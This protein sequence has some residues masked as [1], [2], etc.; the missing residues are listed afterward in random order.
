MPAD[1][2]KT[3]KRSW[4]G[5][6][7][8][9]SRSG[10]AN[11]AWRQG[12]KAEVEPKLQTSQSTRVIIAAASCAVAV[13]LIVWLVLLLRPVRPACLLLVRADYATNLAV[14]HNV[15]GAEGVRGLEELAPPPKG[16]GLFGA[17][18]LRPIDN[19]TRELNKSEEWDLIVQDLRT[20][21][22]F[23]EKTII[24]VMALHGASDASGQPY[25][26]PNN[27]RGP[28]DRLPIKAVLQGLA[29]LPKEKNKVLILE[30]AQIQA[31]WRLGMPHNDF[32]RQLKDLEPEIKGVENLWVL[33]A[34]GPDER[35]WASEGL[36]RTVFSQ[37]LIEGLAGRAAGTD[38]RVDL[39]ELYS[40]VRKNV[41]N[42]SWNA[43]AAIQEPVLLPSGEASLAKAQQVV[44]AST[45]DP[46]RFKAPKEADTSGLERAWRTYEALTKLSPPPWAHA[47]RQW[48]AY[49]AMLV[50]YDELTRAGAIDPAKA[51]ADKMVVLAKN[52][53]EDRF[54][55]L[56][57]ASGNSLVFNAVK[58][59]PVEDPTL[60]ATDLLAYWNAPDSDVNK[61]RQ[62]L[63]A[64]D[65]PAD[66]G[67]RPPVRSLI[68]DF[69]IQRAQADAARNLAR[70][71]ARIAQAKGS[72][73]PQPAEAHFTRMLQ[74]RLPPLEA[75]PELG[76][77][78]QKALS[79]RRLAERAAL[80][81]GEKPD[82]FSYSDQVVPWVRPLIEQADTTRRQA[83]DL[84]F[85]TEPNSWNEADDALSESETIYRKANER[86][87]KVRDA[88]LLRDMVLANL[89][90]YA[91]WTAHRLPAEVSQENLCEPLETLWDGTHR[92]TAMLEAAIGPPNASAS[93][94][95]TENLEALTALARA[96]R[97]GYN[98]V[99]A[100]FAAQKFDSDRD[101]PT[102][103]KQP[104]DWELVNAAAGV[105][106]PFSDFL[107]QRKAIWTR[108]ANI[109]RRDLKDANL[110]L[111]RDSK[112]AKA[113]QANPTNRERE[114]ALNL[115]KDRARIEGRMAL[116]TLGE[117]WFNDP[118][119]KGS[120]NYKGISDRLAALGKSEEWRTS[121]ELDGENQGKRWLRLVPE[122]RENAF[123]EGSQGDPV[124]VRAR[125][126]KADRL[127][128]QLDGAGAAAEADNEAAKKYRERLVHD[129]LLW[130]AE[131][132]WSDH[133]YDEDRKNTPY[134][135]VAGDKYL[136]EAGRLVPTSSEVKDAQRRLKERSRLA[137]E[138]T[139]SIVLTSEASKPASY[140]VVDEGKVP[141][142]SPV[143]SAKAGQ[144]LK[145]DQADSW[146]A[147]KR[148]GEGKPTQPL[149]FAVNCP[150]LE[151]LAVNPKLTRPKADLT[152]FDVQGFF[153]GQVFEARTPVEIHPLP[154]ISVLGPGRPKSADALASLSV[155]ASREIVDQYGEGNGAIAIVLDCSGSMTGT[156]FEKAKSALI[157]VL[158]GV[159]P[160]TRVS[161][162]IYG[163]KRGQPS[164]EDSDEPGRTIAHLH[165]P[166]PWDLNAHLPAIQGKLAGLVPFY[167][168]PLI[169]AMVRAKADL[170]VE[171]VRGFRTLVALTDGGDSVYLPAPVDGGGRSIKNP[172]LAATELKKFADTGILVNVVLFE[173]SKAE[174]AVAERQFKEPLKALD[175]PGQLTDANIQAL[176]EI[177]R[178][179]LLQKL[180]CKIMNNNDGRQVGEVEVTAEGDLSD[181]WLAPG[182]GVG[183]YELQV[184]TDRIFRKKI[185]VKKGDRLI[186]KLVP[187]ADQRLAFERGLYSDDFPM[188]DYP[189]K[190][191]FKGID[192]GNWRLAVVENQGQSSPRSLQLFAILEQNTSGRE[193]LH[194]VRPNL[195]WFELTSDFGKPGDYAVRWRERALYPAPVWQFDVPDWPLDP[196]GAPAAPVL[197][198]W[199]NPDQETPASA[200]L[201]RP[202]DFNAPL[203]DLIER[204]VPVEDRQ[205]IVIESVRAEYHTVEPSPGASPEST[206]CLVVRL[207]YPDAKNPYW[208][209]PE[210]LRGTPPNNFEHRF[211]TGAK[212]YTGL[213]W[214]VSREEITEKLDVLSLISL[215]KFKERT[216][217]R[218]YQLEV[219][220]QKPEIREKPPR[221]PPPPAIPVLQ[222]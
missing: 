125:L 182:L 87:A 115:I 113:P 222:R 118:A 203:R 141:P 12:A 43:R 84:L 103:E 209:D 139:E 188:G 79:V 164:Q 168:T 149:A 106:A 147:V 137:F 126:Q 82:L 42:W 208:I 171:Q 109:G 194:V 130:L 78:A 26:I 129:L 108:L 155:R 47:P 39:Y 22:K 70:A 25:L 80:A 162:L 6:G 45:G 51:L 207:R 205:S 154:E 185:E 88:L 127:S 4:K 10:G 201:S 210:S 48:R 20:K 2:S 41:R 192:A 153:R 196:G 179:A 100:Q 187:G 96:V 158:R 195:T 132:T 54:L 189:R 215:K 57:V 165:P 77:V 169:D 211:Y 61:A 107:E 119:F 89:P 3:P 33:S 53:E 135:Q 160:K 151:D 148:P 173:L 34:A 152:T 60:P 150:K 14:P 204:T 8:S 93:A 99:E 133:W 216:K 221:P 104:G 98:A 13:G 37:Y 101:N 219:K 71:A 95:G 177:L 29:K 36:R 85:A 24:I 74:L 46:P 180:A 199:W 66:E 52:M 163:Q 197:R 121:L 76:K 15:F 136:A 178:K 143:L 30:A 112:A 92:L 50:R 102:G 181:A 213:F 212:R 73:Y 21:N 186:V 220:L 63:E 176:S 166:Q 140:R 17:Q 142:G 55:K 206:P 83:E 146:V 62:K 138:K 191:P 183:T 157:D 58:G 128:R 193:F 145:L 202:A 184:Q 94:E 28:D 59:G 124:T 123:V 175:P 72:D 75:R 7:G 67:R 159:P 31:D 144:F 111:D 218:R 56:P 200:T 69:L 68:D 86:A 1:G 32:A 18:H 120:G 65:S 9:A 172:A 167:G 134:Y 190:E 114:A 214:P 105:A 217:E 19:K 91:R 23:S 81:V 198:A 174:R 131:R 122:I 11:P 40:Y 64:R 116:A 35:C 44:L 117:T 5:S 97:D 90:D 38:R 16:W 49:Q 110:D 170:D 156:K 161:I 27:A